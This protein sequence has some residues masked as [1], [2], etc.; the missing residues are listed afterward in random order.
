MLPGADADVVDADVVDAGAVEAGAE[1][2]GAEDA[3]AEDAGADE[4]GCDDAGDEAGDV[5]GLE[6][7]PADPPDDDVTIGV[8]GMDVPVDADEAW[9]R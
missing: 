2:A 9:L 1:D 8:G 5:P 4:A 6:D 3:G 7:E